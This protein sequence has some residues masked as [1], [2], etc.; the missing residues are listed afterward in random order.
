MA[1]PQKNKILTFPDSQES[2]RVRAIMED[3]SGRARCISKK[4]WAI[5]NLHSWPNLFWF[6]DFSLLKPL[7]A[8]GLFIPFVDNIEMCSIEELKIIYENIFRKLKTEWSA[9]WFLSTFQENPDIFFFKGDESEWALFIR[10]KCVAI[11]MISCLIYL[12][13]FHGKIYIDNCWLRE[14]GG[15]EYRSKTYLWIKKDAID[16]FRRVFGFDLQ[17]LES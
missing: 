14:A 6:V 11:D 2:D 12:F 16:E 10:E 13:G 3:L 9:G 7:C 8:N 17:G 15:I 4:A 5:F 1:P